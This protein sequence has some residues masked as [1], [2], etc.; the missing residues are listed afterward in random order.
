MKPLRKL[1]N[2]FRR[3]KLDAD[4]QAEMRH[5]L[6][7][8]TRRNVQAGMPLTEAA[9]AAQREFGNVAGLQQ[10]AREGRGWLWVEQLGQDLRY[11]L[12]QLRR[13]PGFTTSVVFILALG[14]GAN[15][16]IFSV[17]DTLL[18][19]P[20][21]VRDP[22]GLLAMVFVSPEG[23]DTGINIS[24]PYARAFQEETRSVSEFLAYAS[25]YLPLR[26]AGG[27]VEPGP[28]QLVTDNY[29]S[30]LGVQPTLGRVPGGR[31]AGTKR[32]GRDQP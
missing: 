18:F 31:H 1:R 9:C 11:A 26:A 5:H 17:A 20:L 22:A 24:Q 10:Q 16:A 28:A 3:R 14:L 12:R 32:R 7:E 2:L 29:F 21:P 25:I 15:T 4:M 19:R 27:E 8:Q 13:N 6:E 23:Q 30:S